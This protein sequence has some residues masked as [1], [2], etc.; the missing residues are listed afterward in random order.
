MSEH[1]TECADLLAEVLALR[2][3][4]ADETT[5]LDEYDEDM[6]LAG[7]I[8]P[9]LPPGAKGPLRGQGAI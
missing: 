6:T 5:L 7:W 3:G 4:G 8:P 2:F 1:N 9:A